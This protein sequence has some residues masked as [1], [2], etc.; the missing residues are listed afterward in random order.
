MLW[1]ISLIA[2][3]IRIELTVDVGLAGANSYR[4]GEASS[5]SPPQP[6]SVRPF[7]HQGLGFGAVS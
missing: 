1:T 2:L 6:T 7:K 3:D 4:L 5:V